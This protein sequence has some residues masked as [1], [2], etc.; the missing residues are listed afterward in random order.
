MLERVSLTP[1]VALIRAR[2]LL[3][4]HAYRENLVTPMMTAVTR[5]KVACLRI[6]VVC[7]AK[8]AL[9]KVFPADQMWHVASESF[10]MQ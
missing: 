3:A 8:L 6:K 1:T 7:F 2:V 9:A 10:V 4:L 5:R